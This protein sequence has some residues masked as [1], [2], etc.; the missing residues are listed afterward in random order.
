MTQRRRLSLGLVAVAVLTASTAHA[1]EE[2]KKGGGTS[3]TQ[4]TTLTGA[5]A[6]AGGGRGVLAVE[7]GIDTPDAGL[8][9]RATQM[10]PVLRDAYVQFIVR[11]A[12]SLAPG[13][14]PSADVIGG[15]LQRA[16]DRVL[17]R[18]GATLLLSSI[19]VN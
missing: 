3:F 13:A 4:F 18:P 19:L 16:T 5:V 1:A 8:R 14:P 6:K 11:Y 10:Q 9:L 12:G 7:A 15:E 2:R 17:G